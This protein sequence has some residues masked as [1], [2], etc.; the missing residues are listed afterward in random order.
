MPVSSQKKRITPASDASTVEPSPPLLPGQQEFHHYLL[1]VAPSAS[2]ISRLNQTLAQQFESW[3]ERPTGRA[4]RLR[5]DSEAADR[6][7]L[8][9]KLKQRLLYL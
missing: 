4:T 5:D 2:T 6:L 3:R 7:L 8:T 1:G 9:G